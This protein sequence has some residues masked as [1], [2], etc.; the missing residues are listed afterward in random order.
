MLD[1]AQ[2]AYEAFLNKQKSLDYNFSAMTK[3]EQDAEMLAYTTL[4]IAAT[5]EAEKNKAFIA[6]RTAAF[7]AFDEKVNVDRSALSIEWQTKENNLV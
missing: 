4:K 6:E 1:T 5:Q 3:D 2:K 7:V